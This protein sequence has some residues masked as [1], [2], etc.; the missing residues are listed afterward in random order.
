MN[1]IHKCTSSLVGLSR[2]PKG[3]KGPKGRKWKQWPYRMLIVHMQHR[4]FV[5]KYMYICNFTC[6]FVHIIHRYY[7][8]PSIN[9]VVSVGGEGCQKLPI[10][11]SKQT[12]KRGEG[13]KNRQFWDDIVYGRPLTQ[14]RKLRFSQKGLTSA[15]SLMVHY[16]KNTVWISEHSTSLLFK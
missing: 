7:K 1:L 4:N 2:V 16:C 13:V 9:Y 12:T 14:R 10:L 8:G 3:L 11:H 5:V 15:Y 6:N